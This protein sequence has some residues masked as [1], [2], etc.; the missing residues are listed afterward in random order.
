LLYATNYKPLW[1]RGTTDMSLL[2]IASQKEYLEHDY[3]PSWEPSPVEIPPYSQGMLSLGGWESD[4]LY[5]PPTTNRTLVVCSGG[6]DSGVA[7]WHVHKR[8]DLVHLLHFD[9]QA[10]A[11]NPEREAVMDLSIK[12]HVPLTVVPT[13]FF[14]KNASSPLTDIAHQ[15]NKKLDGETGAEYGHEWV[16][17]RNTVFLA[18]ALAFAEKHGYNRIVLG[19]NLEESGGG[20]PD[21]EQE[22]VNK[23]QALAPYAVR[24][25]TPITFE[26]PL[27]TF[28]KHEIVKLGLSEGAPMELTWSCYEGGNVHCGKCG[29]CYM[30]R[31]AFRMNGAEDPTKYAE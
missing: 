20:Y 1:F 26:Q 24:P 14:A 30:R 22:F 12:M 21:N 23:F 7:A 3:Y 10:K 17:A 29:P 5:S 2:Q 18:L 25:Y 13:N 19:N 27:G 4:V 6:L 28:M 15:I 9:Y 16:P 31:K 8:G 11:T